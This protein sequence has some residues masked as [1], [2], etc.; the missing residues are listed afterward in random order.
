MASSLA[1]QSR[2]VGALILREMSIRYGRANIGYF[3][4][5]LEPAGAILLLALVFS[6]VVHAPPLGSSFALFYA[7]GYICFIFYRNLE[8]RVLS[9]VDGN[10]PLLVYPPVKPIDT[11][12]ARMILEVLT[13]AVATTVIIAVILIA[14]ELHPQ[15]R[16]DYMMPALLFASL[17]GVGAGMIHLVLKAVWQ[18]WGQIHGIITRP[19]FIV[20][21]IFYIP[22]AM[23]KPVRDILW[24]NPVAH[25]ISLFRKG[26]YPTYRAEQLSMTY[27][28]SCSVGAFLIGLCLVHI[29]R[30]RIVQ[31]N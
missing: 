14:W 21:G 16:F 5:I 8:S 18:S 29:Y 24:F 25:Y 9:A 7:T 20:S 3:W 15:L 26:F 27:L 4:A 1:I 31:D 28:V 22:E 12:W 23:P 6:F 2:V 17:F 13:L 30:L 10:R 11:I 19:M